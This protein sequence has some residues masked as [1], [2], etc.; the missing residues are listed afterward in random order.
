MKKT[1]KL[2]GIFLCLILCCLLCLPVAASASSHKVKAGFFAFS[3]YHMMDDHGI[4]SGYGYDYLQYMSN[5]EDWSYDYVGYDKSWKDMLGMLE[6]GEIDLLTSVQKTPELEKRFAFSNDPIGYSSLIFTVKA[7]NTKYLAGDYENFNGMKVGLIEGRSR[8]KLFEA[9]AAEHGFD[10]TPVYFNNIED[11]EAA[12]MDGELDAAVTSTLRKIENE[13]VLD[14]FAS[15]PFYAIVR[16]DDTRLLEDVNDAIKQVKRYHPNLEEELYQK[17]YI[18]ASGEEIAFTV[19][20]Q[21]YIQECKDKGT[22]LKVLLNPDRT[23]LSWFENGQAQ[24]VFA[25][26]GQQ[27]LNRSGI[28]YE[29]PEIKSREEYQNLLNSGSYDIALDSSVDFNRAEKLGYKLTKPYM[30]APIFQITQKDFSGK[31]STL[32]ALK[33]ADVTLTYAERYFP[34]DAITYYDTIEEC[35]QAVREHKQDAVFFYSYIA[36]SILYN[37]L[38]NNLVAKEIP[39]YTN[40]FAIAVNNTQDER[41]LPILEKSLQSI[42]EEEL[43]ELIEADT[44]FPPKEQNVS[45]FLRSHPLITAAV[46]AFL[47]ITALIIIILLYKNKGR[48]SEKARLNEF[49]RFISYVCR[50]NDLVLELDLKEGK[51]WY[52]TAQ[53]GVVNITPITKEQLNRL[54]GSVCQEDAEKLNSKLTPEYMN[55]LIDQGTEFYFECRVLRDDPSPHWYAFTIQGLARDSMHP[56]SIMIF[57]HDIDS[58][59]QTEARQRKVL[60]DALAAA[61]QASETKSSFLS[62]MSHEMRTPLNAIIGYLEIGRKHVDDPEKI[63]DYMDKS[64]IAAHQLLSIINDVLDMAAIE[65]GKLHLERVQFE[66]TEEILAVQK[67]FETQAWNKELDFQVQIDKDEKVYIMGDPLRLNQILINLLSNAIKF[68]PPHGK[69]I[70]RVK[71]TGQQDG[72]VYYCFEV[73]DTGIGMSQEYLTHL[74]DPFEQHDA[75]IARRYGGSGLGM[76]ITK[77]LVNIKNGTITVKSKLNEGTTF[78]VNLPFELVHSTP[79]P[80]NQA[81]NCGTASED[82]KNPPFQFTG[83]R[84]MLA[85][86]NQMNREIAAEILTSVGFKVDCAVDGKDA[87]EQFS[88]SAPDTY[89]L[90]L[91]DIQM[92]V[93]DGY[94]AAE[95]I[96][97]SDHPQAKTI[98]IFAM[99][100]NAFTEDINKALA[101]GMNGHIAKPLDVAKM[102]ETLSKTLYHS[103]ES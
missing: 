81:D 24:G 47:F 1:K 86:D 99:T 34:P 53:N 28:P 37:D 59:K 15:S 64:D 80:G 95:H 56:N 26:L 3:G 46:L 36:Q 51:S 87:V 89:Q 65:S 31:V 39:G 69:V 4:R 61:Q 22:P 17:Y 84:L 85:E 38:E 101:S 27:V 72:Q 11:L 97:A 5:Y 16:K 33:N 52:Y 18:P 9:Y 2:L 42:S 54:S 44:K 66:L 83:M 40:D 7:R 92:P 50:M 79:E 94:E 20:E 96:R 68:T 14:E 32:A 102:L 23:P 45:S 73:T 48:K 35:T 43:N 74:F 77:N 57:G 41:L 21:S 6:A 25:H 63:K 62:R 76:S 93:M 13:W 70:L 88:S 90:I 82:S 49:E 100:A 30:T 60:Q 91:M 12:L 10:Y 98:P 78:T 19:D 71:R 67:M 8:N 103:D 29:I 75:S 58:A 55:S